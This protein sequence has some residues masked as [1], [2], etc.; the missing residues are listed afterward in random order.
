MSSHSWTKIDGSLDFVVKG[1][2]YNLFYAAW[3]P[4]IEPC[5][6]HIEVLSSFPLFVRIL[7]IMLRW[8]GADIF[9]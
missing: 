2:C 4:I 1:Y 6:V 3:E 5:P 7:N 8:S 9:R